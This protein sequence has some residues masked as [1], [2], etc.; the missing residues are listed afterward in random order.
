MKRTGAQIIT[1]LL[2]LEGIEFVSGIPGGSIL[3][4]YDELARSDIR[5]ILARHEQAAGFIAQGAA[6]S[7]GKPAVCLATSGPGAMNLLTAIADARCDSVPIV[8]ITG[9][10]SASLIGTDAFQEA[11]TFGLSF[12]IAKHSMMVKSPE[13]LLDAIP[14]AFAIATNGRAGPVLVDVPRDAQTA[15]CEFDEWPDVNA[16]KLKE[17]RFHTPEME[18]RR[19]ME[20]ITDMLARAR[21]PVLLCGGGCN[22]PDAAAEINKFIKSYRLPVVSTLMGLG[23]VA[24]SSGMFAGMVG[25]HGAYSANVA[26]N[27]SDFVIAAGARFDDRA[28][29]LVEKFCPNAKIAHIDV[30][31]A[32]V[33]K[34]IEADISVVADLKDVFPILVKL[35]ADKQELFAREWREA[36]ARAIWLEKI[37]RI[38]KE[39]FSFESGRDSSGGK[40]NP[41][42][43]IARIPERAEGAGLSREDLIV[44]TDVGQHQMWAAQYYPV[45][46]PRSFLTSGSLGV[47][48]FGLPAAIGAAIANPGKRALCVSGDGSILMNIQELAT[49]SELNLAVTVIVFENKTLGMVRQQQKYLFGESYSASE[50]ERCPDL[51]AVA[52]GFGVDAADADDDE[53][54]AEKAFSAEREKKPFLLR[55]KISAD[56][57]VLP[58]VTPNSANIDAIR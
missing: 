21:R 26:M 37:M 47:M 24:E 43:F 56:E 53:R 49:L 23:C 38:K 57:D 31:A 29:G 8:A 32:E 45:E 40:T 36:E 18:Y 25:M 30:D 41:R 42:E 22:S 17:I 48:G 15:S 1:K 11:D 28:T 13:E 7:S 16:V 3:P 19:R 44:T 6:R 54:W 34:I 27:E 50:F 35:S 33:D 39:N 10:V 58:Y 12:P 20:R 5:H 9:Q 52:R 51:V 4:L 46:R 14:K 2:E 55:V